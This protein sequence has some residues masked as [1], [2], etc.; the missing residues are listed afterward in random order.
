MEE[1]F[2]TKITINE[3][4][5]IRDFEIPLS[6]KERRHL[7]L[8]GKNGSG[9][10]T[11][12]R[13]IAYILHTSVRL[14]KRD[15]NLTRK[16]FNVDDFVK[17]IANLHLDVN[18][19]ID[20]IKERIIAGDFILSYFIATRNTVFS[21]PNGIVKVRKLPY[22]TIDDNAGVQFIQY[23]VSLMADK[24]FARDDSKFDEVEKI[25][26]WFQNF[27]EKILDI[28]DAKG[29]QLVF[30]R[31]SYNFNIVE[32]GKQPYNLNQLSDGYSAILNIVTELIM[33]MEEHKT[34]S[35]DVQG[36]VLI[37]EIETHLHI[38]L[39][40]KILPFLTSFFPKIQF[41]VTTHS[42]FVINSIENAVV[43]DLEK[44]IVLDNLSGYSYDA[45]VEG[46]FDADKYSTVL[47]QQVEEFESLM[48]KDELTETE[49]RRLQELKKYLDGIPKF[50]SDELAVK[51]QQI[52]LKNLN[53]KVK[54]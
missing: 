16:N 44:R 1:I 2:A 36:I 11:V 39:Q 38:E 25:D 12:L 10:T 31:K 49:D 9:K 40:K 28:F 23:I 18:K 33:R 54:K 14:A 19:D 7:I 20:T 45:I 17:Q 24:S 48:S 29:A 52:R 6:E 3:V 4:M 53:K 22:Y 27:E 47:K 42:P 41:I 51:L 21:T 30:D 8:T 34:K 26:D 46:Y 5:N 15:Q 37:D 32:P 50:L 43:C 35:Y 13:N